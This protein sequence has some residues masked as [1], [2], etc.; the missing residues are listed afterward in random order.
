MHFTS[1]KECNPFSLTN[2][3]VALY[4]KG[5]WTRSCRYLRAAIVEGWQAVKPDQHSP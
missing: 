5:I 1:V 3:Y 4:G 2:V